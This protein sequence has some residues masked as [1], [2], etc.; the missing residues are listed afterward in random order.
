MVTPRTANQ[1]T[2]RVRTVAAVVG[3]LVVAAL[4]VGQAGVV[5][6]DGVDEAGADLRSVVGVADPRA[7]AGR[8]P[9]LVAGLQ[10]EVALAAARQGWC[11]AS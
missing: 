2:A 1:A 7:V 4:G 8:D 9:V 3:G 6:D 5:V 10:P 11:R